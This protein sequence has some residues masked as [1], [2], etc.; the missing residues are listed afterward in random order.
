MRKDFW[1]LLRDWLQD[2]EKDWLRPFRILK[3]GSWGSKCTSGAQAKIYLKFPSSP[4]MCFF[5]L[6]LSFAYPSFM[7]KND[8]KSET[9]RLPV[10]LQTDVC[11]FRIWFKEVEPTSMICDITNGLAA[12]SAAAHCKDKQ[13]VNTWLTY[14]GGGMYNWETF[15]SEH[16]KVQNEK[17]C[18]QSK[19]DAAVKAGRDEWRL[20]CG[21]VPRN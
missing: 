11:I 1:C 8:V 9:A 18:V 19:S 4:K 12:N 20:C 6:L 5:F 13:N 14:F 21:V 17:G 15:R 7:N 10:H 2:F 16:W 3:T